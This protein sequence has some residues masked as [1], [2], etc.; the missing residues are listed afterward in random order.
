M[1]KLPLIL[2][3]AI[4]LCSQMPL[5]KAS[6]HEDAGLN[7]AIAGD[8]RSESNKAR[9]SYRR[10]FETLRFLGITDKMTVIESWPGGGWYTEILAPYLKN[11]GQLIAATYDRNPDSQKSWMKRLNQNFDDKFVAHPETYGNIAVVGLLPSS[12]PELAPPGSVDA[13]LDFRNAH[14]WIKTDADNLIMAW[15]KALR[16]GGIV[17]LVDHRMDDDKEYNPNNGYVHE[18]QI[19]DAM[20]KHG[21]KLEARSDLNRNPK[22]TK[23][24]PKGV[25]T[26]PPTLALKDQDREKYLAIGESDRML[27]KFVKQ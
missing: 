19:I 1:K 13:V 23:D 17:G 22:D 16:S 12:N 18:K 5:V 10:P 20:A 21:F 11:G 3:V 14:N 15:H 8:H 2:S 9:D 7:A 6:H 24:H 4:L 25:W 26:L 27:L